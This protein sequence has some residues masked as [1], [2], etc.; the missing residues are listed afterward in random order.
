MIHSTPA[1]TKG[2]AF[3]IAFYNE[4]WDDLFRETRVDLEWVLVE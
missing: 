4:L 3:E 2:H 1:R